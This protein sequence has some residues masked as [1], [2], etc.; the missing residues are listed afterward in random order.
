MGAGRLEENRHLYK[1]PILGEI[2]TGSLTKKELIL[3]APEEQVAS[4]YRQGDWG[5]QISVSN[6]STQAETWC[7]YDFSLHY[8]CT[9]QLNFKCNIHHD[10]PCT[11]EEILLGSL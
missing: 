11:W 8:D 6:K 4:S 3:S 1:A 7:V 2:S 5:V 9:T 10:L